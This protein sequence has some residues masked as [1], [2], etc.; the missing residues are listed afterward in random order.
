[1]LRATTSEGHV[2]VMNRSVA[3]EGANGTRSSELADRA[4][5]RA[6]LNE[7]FGFDLP[8]VLSLHVPSIEE[9]Q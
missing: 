5:L 7:R 6:L 8:E 2:S 4:A 3:H 1:M 9:W